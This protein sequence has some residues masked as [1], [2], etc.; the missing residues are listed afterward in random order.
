[1][2]ISDVPVYASI[3]RGQYQLKC[4]KLNKYQPVELFQLLDPA[5]GFRANR[6]SAGK[7][8]DDRRNIGLNADVRQSFTYYPNQLPS[9]NGTMA[10]DSGHYSLHDSLT[11][12]FANG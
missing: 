8:K 6:S 12:G 11:I 5:T 3:Q 9:R 7:N 4:I 1:M 2:K 10:G